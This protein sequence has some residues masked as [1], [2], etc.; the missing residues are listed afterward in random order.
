MARRLVSTLL[1]RSAFRSASPSR[2][3][4]ALEVNN[5]TRKKTVGANRRPLLLFDE[6][7]LLIL[8]VRIEEVCQLIDALIPRSTVGVAMCSLTASVYPVPPSLH[9]LT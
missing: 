8:A 5:D 4:P 6:V 7:I 2:Q 1:S 9:R 3:K